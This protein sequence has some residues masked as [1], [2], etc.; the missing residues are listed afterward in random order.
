MHITPHYLKVSQTTLNL[1]VD[2]ASTQ[3]D[4][5]QYVVVNMQTVI[6][7]CVSVNKIPLICHLVTE[8]FWSMFVEGR[9][10]FSFLSESELLVRF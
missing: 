6:N 3:K 4:E 5:C 9:I 1:Y 2:H 8:F 10:V 7:M